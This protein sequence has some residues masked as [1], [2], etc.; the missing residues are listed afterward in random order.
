MQSL[1]NN[2]RL[3]QSASALGAALLGFAIGG[4]W[5]SEMSTTILIATL[6][7]GAI[8]HVAGMYVMQMKDQAQIGT[9]AKILW[10]TAWICLLSLLALFIYLAVTDN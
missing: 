6:V 7:I 3:A 9:I 4:M 10:V 5:G 8:I 2:G 1:N